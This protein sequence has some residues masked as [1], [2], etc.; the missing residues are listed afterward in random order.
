VFISASDLA[1]EELGSNVLN[2]YR[3]F[4]RL[5]PSA[6]IEDGVFVFDGRFEVPLASA[7]GH[8]QR[9]Q[10]SLDHQQF[11]DALAESQAAVNAAPNDMQPQIMLGDV[12]TA[13]HR[14]ARPAYE[15][16]LAI[17]QTMEPEAKAI[18]TT[19]IQQKLAHLQQ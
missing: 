18:W 12:L 10:I 6:F 7:L 13:M 16:A 14:N 3:N 1:G 17:P 15:K 8:I 11:E 19:T 5:H 2:P 4:Q 9:S